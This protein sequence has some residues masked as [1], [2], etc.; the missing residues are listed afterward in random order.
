[1][2]D[3]LLFDSSTSIAGSLGANLSG[4]VGPGLTGTIEY[5]DGTND[6][7]LHVVPEPASTLLVLGGLGMI[8]GLRRRRR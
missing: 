8:A 3:Y 1:M 6:L 2:G 4:T 5:T 7:R